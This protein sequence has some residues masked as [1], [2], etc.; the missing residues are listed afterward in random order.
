MWQQGHDEWFTDSLKISPITAWYAVMSTDYMCPGKNDYTCS[1]QLTK[2]VVHVFKDPRG[3]IWLFTITFLKWFLV[4]NLLI[5]DNWVPC[6]CST[7]TGGICIVAITI[8]CC[9]DQTSI[10]YY[11][12]YIYYHWNISTRPKVKLHTKEI[13]NPINDTISKLKVKLH[14]LQLVLS[15][16]LG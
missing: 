11:F 9:W 1:A 2:H 3:V 5:Q 16:V 4:V 13:G 10:N 14:P 7:I 8:G 6:C 12:Y 15:M